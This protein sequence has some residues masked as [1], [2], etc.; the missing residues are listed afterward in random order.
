MD[1][2]LL[3]AADLLA[4]SKAV[5]DITIPATV[6]QPAA[7]GANGAQPPTPAPAGCVR[8]RPLSIAVLTLIAR[9]A[10][11]DAGLVPLLMIKE[12]LV[13]PALSL[14]QIRQLHVGLVYFLVEQINRLSGLA[15]DGGTLDAAAASPLGRTHILLAKHFGWTPEQVGQLT[16][17]Q[18]AVYL[19]GIEKLLQLEQS[20]AEAGAA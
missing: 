9:A 18:V 2:Q 10:R 14:D 12:A 11:D 17:G 13:E 3:S 5:Q 6:L 15:A 8:L 19:A 4:G 7:T 16:P 1:T 20:R